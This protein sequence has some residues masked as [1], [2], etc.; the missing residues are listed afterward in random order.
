[1][2]GT[3]SNLEPIVIA[4]MFGTSIM[5]RRLSSSCRFECRK[6]VKGRYRSLRLAVD[7]S[8]VEPRAAFEQ[9]LLLAASA[10]PL[11]WPGAF[12]E[13]PGDDGLLPPS[14]TAKLPVDA[15]VL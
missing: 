4:V 7:E 15:V 2:N 14:G 1:M 5:T 12:S 10:Q 8:A 9:A 3:L 13:F 11:L 6:L